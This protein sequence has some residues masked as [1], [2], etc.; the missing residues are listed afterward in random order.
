MTVT[1]ADFVWAVRPTVSDL[2]LTEGGSMT[3]SA[4]WSAGVQSDAG[5][6]YAA[7]AQTSDL[8]TVTDNATL[9]V[10]MDP[11][12]AEG[13]YRAMLSVPAYASSW[14]TPPYH[15]YAM[16]VDWGGGRGTWH[17]VIADTIHGGVSADGFVS[18]STD[19]TTCYAI[20]RSGTT[21]EWIR[22]G[23][24]FD[25]KSIGGTGAWDYSPSGDVT[26]GSRSRTDPG[27]GCAGTYYFV[28]IANR[29][30]TDAELAA[31]AADP[32][33]FEGGAITGLIAVTDAADTSSIAAT[34]T[35][36]TI[37]GSMASVKAD[38]QCR[39]GANMRGVASGRMPT[40]GIVTPRSRTSRY[41]NPALNIVHGPP[42]PPPES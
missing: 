27:E 16:T 39:I 14:H 33:A 11:N 4:F 22:N 15:V 38:D 29:L 8:Q 5:A 12:T 3:G 25:T 23:I 9:V 31:I 24:V 6:G 41:Y 32:L 1:L 26:V 34:V 7:W 40:R 35:T 30:L 18:T 21:V 10:V 36:V 13:G 20:R 2:E 17:S 37:T 28:G 19:P 42:P